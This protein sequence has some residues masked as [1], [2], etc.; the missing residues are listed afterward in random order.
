MADVLVDFKDELQYL[1][2]FNFVEFMFQNHIYLF[3]GYNLPF[4][5]NELFHLPYM[6]VEEIV[7]E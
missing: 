6:A 7:G 2:L 3:I 1:E 5:H 4:Q